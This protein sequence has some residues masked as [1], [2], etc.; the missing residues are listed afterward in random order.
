[1]ALQQMSNK[2]RVKTETR[3]DERLRDKAKAADKA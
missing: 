1:M 2:K 3:R